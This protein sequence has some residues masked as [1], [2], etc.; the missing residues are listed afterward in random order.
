M[1]YAKSNVS[2]SAHEDA[3][4]RTG[5]TSRDHAPRSLLYST[6]RVGTPGCKG[7]G[8]VATVDALLADRS[9]FEPHL[10]PELRSYLDRHP[11]AA[12]WYPGED[13]IGLLDALVEGDGMPPGSR[14]ETYEYFGRIAVRRDV[15]GDQRNVPRSRRSALTG[16]F[17]GAIH[18]K[19]DHA[20]ALRR[21][22]AIWQ[23][24]WEEGE[25]VASR[26]GARTLRFRMVGCAPSIPEPCWIYNGLCKESL[27]ALGIAAT[28]EH[29]CTAE[30]A[31]QCVWTI[32][33]DVPPE[34]LESFPEAA[35]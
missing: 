17:E 21:L 7:V 14:R 25:I 1:P 34:V 3:Q 24:Y 15:T 22:C 12:R 26:V 20:S 6:S 18:E 32:E 11:V 27:D 33:P 19:I 35:S 4:R 5:S 30:G 13:L 8:M 29:A 31:P 2:S 28:I 16:A 10:R 23:L 9:R